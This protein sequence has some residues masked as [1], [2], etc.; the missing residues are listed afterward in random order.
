MSDNNHNN[1]EKQ[2]D[3]TIKIK[4]G[5]LWRYSTF[6]LLALLVVGA[7][8]F[9]TGGDD[10]GNVN[11][12]GNTGGTPS[13]VSA[14]A[15][16]DAVLGDADAPVTIIEFSDYQCPFCGRFYAQTLPLLK[17]QYV[18]TGKVKMVFRDFPLT[19]IHPMAMP[20]AQ[21]TEC[22][23]EEGGDDAFWEMHDVLFENQESLSNANLIMWAKEIG[24]D[25]EDCLN[26]GKYASE[27]QNDIKDAVAAGGQGTPYFVINGKPL[28]GAQPFE[29]FQQIIESEL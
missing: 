11:N 8:V 9:F 12:N 7:F 29:A 18:D 23:R 3:L 21:A 24:Y 2:G 28:S 26:S 5:D 25:I 27:V 19:Q 20:A 13:Q 22:V 17:S 16:D 1:K 14:D 10:N 4:K 15:D 6:L